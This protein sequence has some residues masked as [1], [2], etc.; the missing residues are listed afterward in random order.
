MD[1]E[2][3]HAEAVVHL[4][5][6]GTFGTGREGLDTIDCRLYIVQC[7]VH[8]RTGIHLDPHGGDARSRYGLDRL[9]VIEPADL[10]LDLDDDRLLDLLRRGTGIGHR[11]FDVVEGGD[12]P[13]FPLEAGQGHESGRNDA[14][15][16][17]IGRDAVSGHV[18]ERAGPL[19]A[20]AGFGTRVGIHRTG[21]RERATVAGA[22][23]SM[24]PIAARLL[25]RMTVHSPEV[26]LR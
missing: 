17:E 1:D 4:L 10:V 5:E 25:L 6:P 7:P 2:P 26:N 3:H 16:Q 9:H 20:V 15:H 18:G 13:G 11:D 14:Q 12:R 22:P 19:A 21:S 23:R 24:A 8:V